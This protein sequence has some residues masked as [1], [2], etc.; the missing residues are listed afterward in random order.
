M[1]VRKWAILMPHTNIRQLPLESSGIEQRMH[2][3]MVILHDT[4]GDTKR[5]QIEKSVWCTSFGR[6]SI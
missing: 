5:R 1:G 2:R 3:F 6:A 4:R